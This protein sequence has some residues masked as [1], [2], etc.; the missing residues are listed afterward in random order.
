[1]ADRPS[2]TAR[3]HPPP[4]RFCVGCAEPNGTA[5][6]CPR[7][8]EPAFP[9]QPT[10]PRRA[11][12]R[13]RWPLFA[14]SLAPLALLCLILV[15]FAAAEQAT[16]AAWYARGEAAVATGRYPEAVSAFAAAGGHRDASTR[17]RQLTSALAPIVAAEEAAAAALAAGR[18]AVAIAALQPIPRAVRHDATSLALLAEARALY[19]AE[20]ERDAAAAA[21]HREWLVAERALAALAGLP[22]DPTKASTLAEPAARLAELRRDHAPIAITRDRAL[23]LVGPD[24]A[25]DRLLLDAVP[26]ARPV[27]SPDRTRIAFVSAPR[28]TDPTAAVLYVVGSDG[29]GLRRLSDDIHPNALPAW[30][31]NGRRIAYTSVAA[32]NARRDEGRLT[33]HVADL[34]TGAE[35]DVAAALGRVGRADGRGATARHAMSPWWVPDGRLTVIGRA[36]GPD[37]GQP[38][39]GPGDVFL[40]D[41]AAGTAENLTLGRVP[42][43]I[44]VVWSPRGD[45]ALL[46]ARAWNGENGPLD[47]RAALVTLH[48]AT[49][50]LE[51]VATGIDAAAPA[52][53]PAW[54]PDG[55]RF[56]YVEGFATVVLRDAAGRTRRLP[57]PGLLS[58]ALSWAPGGES[59][60]AVAA[61]PSQ[62]SHLI[63]LATAPPAITPLRTAADADRRAGTPQ[64]SP[65]LPALDPTPPALSGTAFDPARDILM[66]HAAAQCRVMQSSSAPPSA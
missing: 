42:D 33:V 8:G 17:R 32:W 65:V 59:L 45:R 36:P 47:A 23:W 1:M 48:L 52:W 43:L 22:P 50:A 7:C 16:S 24:G 10:A 53:S 37:P 54:A 57:L 35:T 31:P 55:A 12:A 66:P 64:W 49:G 11:D 29:N 9:F 25:D 44:R 13:R 14:L 18:P 34:A 19:R 6:R 41:L 38:A 27:W 5:G 46:Y 62:S 3:S 30:S 63:D 60:L 39:G 51:P 28:E 56:A 4:V 40:L 58:G 21:T 20:L 2:L 61:D 15:S 26:V